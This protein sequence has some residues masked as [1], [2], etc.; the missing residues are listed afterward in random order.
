M[1]PGFDSQGGE[2]QP[3]FRESQWSVCGGS[4]PQQGTEVTMFEYI[5][6]GWINGQWATRTVCAD[7]SS[8]AEC[9]ASWIFDVVSFIQ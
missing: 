4:I 1:K 5:V 8:E 3:L 9:L 2:L 6:G 7:R